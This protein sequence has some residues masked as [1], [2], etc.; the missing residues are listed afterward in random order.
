[1]G[2]ERASKA[3]VA[4]ACLRVDIIVLSM[5]LSGFLKESILSVFHTER[6]VACVTMARNTMWR[7]VQAK[8]GLTV[9]RKFNS[10]CSIDVNEARSRGHVP[11]HTR[12]VES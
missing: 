3:E 9:A 12:C 7:M 4:G 8:C 10:I 11:L 5:F 1:M 2:G 6:I